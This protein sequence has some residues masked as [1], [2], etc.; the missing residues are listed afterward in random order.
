[1]TTRRPHFFVIAVLALVLAAAT[2]ARAQETLAKAKDFYATAA[3]EEALQVLKGLKGGRQRSDR[4]GRL[5][6][7]LSLRARAK[8]RGEESHRVDRARRSA[9]SSVRFPGLA[10]RARF[11]RGVRR[12]LL[13]EVVRQ[14]YSEAKDAYDRKDHADR[15]ERIRSRHYVARRAERRRRSGRRRSSDA[16]GRVSRS[17]QS[18]GRS[19]SSAGT[20]ASVA[21]RRCPHP[22]RRRRLSLSVRPSRGSTPSAIRM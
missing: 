22:P 7:V 8:R 9:V 18:R 10:A 19:A 11:L 17:Q 5:P 13:P 3:Y 14:S 16:G 21:R 6:G 2:A 15:V 1:M 20:A 12:P 4:S